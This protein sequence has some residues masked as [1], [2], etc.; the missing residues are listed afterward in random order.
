MKNNLKK[1][2]RST[3]FLDRTKSVSNPPAQFGILL[4]ESEQDHVNKSILESIAMAG[5][6]K[7]GMYSVGVDLMLSGG[8][9]LSELLSQNA[10]FV[11][12]FG[13]VA[14]RGS[15]GS[16][17]KLVTPLY[18]KAYWLERVGWSAN[19][20]R[21]VSRFTWY[22]FLKAQGVCMHEKGRGNNIVTHAARKLQAHS[23]FNAGV[24]LEGIRD[25]MGHRSAS[26]TLFY[27]AKRL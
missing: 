19:P 13:Q 24:E 18:H 15:K 14:I 16:A 22:R 7:L 21:I 17:D 4:Q 3:S 2:I 9:R 26:S 11:T 5:V 6:D 10:F 20:F 25:I 23:L 12:P 8:L 1:G 27:G